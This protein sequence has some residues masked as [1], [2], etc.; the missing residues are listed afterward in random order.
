[1][2]NGSVAKV[3]VVEDDPDI[4]KLVTLRIQNQGHRVL[5]VADAESALDEV[6]RRGAPD[7]AVL[8]INLPNM[9]GFDLCVAL[10]DAVNRPDLPVIFLTARVN[11]DDVERGRALGFTT[12]LTKPLVTSSLLAA[13]AEHTA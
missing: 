3:L 7:V 2:G 11:Y 10:R 12:Y 8:D 1:M 4:R 13:V 5:A 9:N 6:A